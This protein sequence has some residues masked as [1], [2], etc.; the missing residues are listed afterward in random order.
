MARFFLWQLGI[1]P[2]IVTFSAGFCL[3]DAIWGVPFPGVCLKVYLRAAL[4]PNM[5]HYDVMSFEIT[6]MTSPGCE[7]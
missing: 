6:L 3:T 4:T 5:T 7:L 1:F 2:K